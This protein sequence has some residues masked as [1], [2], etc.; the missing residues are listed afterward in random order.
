M[1]KRKKNI[2]WWI[3]QGAIKK[4]LATAKAAG[5]KMIIL[6][7]VPRTVKQA[8]SI[9][10]IFEESFSGAMHFLVEADCPD[11]IALQRAISRK[12]PNDTDPLIRAAHVYYNKHRVAIHNSLKSWT[13][14]VKFSTNHK[15]HDGKTIEFSSLLIQHLRDTRPKGMVS[16]FPQTGT[17]Q[18]A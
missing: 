18:S 9:R 12:G 3:I 8:Q 15:T 6:D 14:H 17:K 1:S 4:E 5:F 7:G 11:E 16:F 10:E 13:T 2:A